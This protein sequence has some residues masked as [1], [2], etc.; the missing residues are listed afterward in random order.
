MEQKTSKLAWLK[1]LAFPVGY[2]VFMNVFQTATLAGYAFYCVFRDVIVPIASNSE[3]IDMFFTILQG[4]SEY[5]STH[6]IPN[7][8]VNEISSSD[9]V[10][11]ISALTSV[12]ALVVLWLV[13][14]RKKRNF[15]EYFHFKPTSFGYIAA[16][17]LLGLGLFFV[18]NAILTLA[19]M[20]I[21][22]LFFALLGMLHEMGLGD[23]A[24]MIE[25]IYRTS[26]EA[27]AM[28]QSW[29]WFVFAAVLFAPLIEELVFRAGAITNL[30]KNLP[31]WACVLIS[32]ALFSFAHV[33]SLNLWQ[34]IYTFLLGAMIA[35]LLIKS[36][37]I[38]PAILC[39]FCFNG[40]N[41]VVLTL[42]KLLSI[43]NIQGHP[44]V[45]ED[46]F[47]Q[48][49]THIMQSD[50]DKL[51]EWYNSIAMLFTIVTALLG[52][53]M[54]IA[55]LILLFKLRPYAPKQEPE[56]EEFSQPVEEIPQSAEQ[57][58]ADALNADDLWADPPY[59][60]Q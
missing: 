48:S 50:P 57:L 28:P 14:N 58:D 19:S 31:V 8:L 34:L 30:K 32:S 33:G 7:V 15:L 29:S 10:W 60:A 17:V 11:V 22:G 18:V 46:Y 53:L 43:D 37:S 2:F 4:K 44:I 59:E 52:V 49:S 40:A 3:S 27:A 56:A 23:L 54:L 9:V 35:L 39:H 55:G 6:Y 1:G 12:L 21:E 36:D 25:E 26:Q 16:S 41:I 13:F 20:A 24:L 47:F 51:L 42:G 45:P 38:Y 5:L